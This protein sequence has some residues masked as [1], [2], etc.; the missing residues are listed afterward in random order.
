MKRIQTLFGG[1]DL[2]WTKLVI[3][4]V[5]AGLYTGLMALLPIAENTSFEDISIS[6]EWWILFGILIIMNSQTPLDSALKCFVFFLISQPLVY[7]VQVPFYASG[8][9]IFGYY[10]WWFRWTLL[11]F[12][13]G[14]IGYYMKKGRWWGLGILA[15]M[16]ALLGYHYYGFLNETLSWFPHHLLSAIFCAAT[17]LLY[18]VVIL[19]NK[20]VQR[21]GLVFAAAILIVATILSAT[22]SHVFYSTT[23]CASGEP[24]EANYFDPSYTV[25]LADESYGTVSIEYET[26]LDCYV[27]NAELQKPGATELILTA[28]NGEQTTYTLTIAKNTY[29]L[30]EKVMPE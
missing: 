18:P 8:W 1:L 20:N 10:R 24:G 29:Q 27:V 17:M 22:S 26:Q 4:A 12:P 14:F 11:T 3:F 7:L 21:A 6:F 25:S 13:M 5:I 9:S 30:R 15:P 28:P 23:L 16:I 19:Q 2:S